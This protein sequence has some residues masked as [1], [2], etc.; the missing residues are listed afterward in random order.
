M[1]SPGTKL[2]PYEILAAIGAGFDVLMSMLNFRVPARRSLGAGRPHR[3][4]LAVKGAG[5]SFDSALIS[6][7]QP[8]FRPPAKP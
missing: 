4:T 5:L 3:F 7:D 2:G 8:N 6:Q 1:L